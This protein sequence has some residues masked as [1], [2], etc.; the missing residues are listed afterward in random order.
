MSAVPTANSSLTLP[1]ANTA[2]MGRVCPDLEAKALRQ[3]RRPGLGI[4][5]CTTGASSRAARIRPISNS[6]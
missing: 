2:G 3:D 1:M 6:A 4:C 5:P